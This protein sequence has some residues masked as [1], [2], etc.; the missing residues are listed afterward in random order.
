MQIH[1]EKD[2]DVLVLTVDDRLDSATATEFEQ[3]LLSVIDAGEN[4]LLLDFSA[5]N[6]MNSAGLK[7]LLIAAKKLTAKNG[8]VVLCGLA[9]N[10]NTVFE[11]TGFHKMFTIKPDRPAARAAFA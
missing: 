1:E 6:Y 11:L 9:S 4:L 2:G 10:V 8:Q 5:L 7:A 3:R